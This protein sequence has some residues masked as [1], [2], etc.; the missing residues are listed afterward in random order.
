MFHM[1][2]SE[3]KRYIILFPFQFFVPG[4]LVEKIFKSVGVSVSAFT[5]CMHPCACQGSAAT[6]AAVVLMSVIPAKKKEAFHQC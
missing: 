4:A 3:A 5:K 1:T 2:K 6:P